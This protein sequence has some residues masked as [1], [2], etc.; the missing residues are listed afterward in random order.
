V[1]DCEFWL[2]VPVIGTVE[3]RER[4]FDCKCLFD[5][6]LFDNTRGGKR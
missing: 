6:R 5:K 3:N 1:D 4:P 2:P